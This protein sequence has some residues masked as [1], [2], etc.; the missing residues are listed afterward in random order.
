MAPSLDDL[1]QEVVLSVLQSLESRVAVR[2]VTRG[3]QSAVDAHFQVKRFR[4]P[5]GGSFCIDFEIDKDNS[6]SKDLYCA[7]F[8]RVGDDENGS[9][10][11]VVSFLNWA[12]VYY[13]GSKNQRRDLRHRLGDADA[14]ALWRNVAQLLDDSG[15]ENL[16]G[17]SPENL[18]TDLNAGRSAHLVVTEGFGG[19]ADGVRHVL[20][21]LP[22]AETARV[23]GLID[24]RW[25]SSAVCVANGL[26]KE[27]CC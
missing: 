1:P 26:T 21:K 22:A 20:G 18:G 13:R 5:S 12:P 9:V 8:S 19:G 23:L 15:A 6:Q 2:A 10:E 17:G 3:W 25:N 11:G 4:S 7:K 24:H 14:C 27:G 16:G